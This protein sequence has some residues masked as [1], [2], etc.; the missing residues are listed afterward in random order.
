MIVNLSVLYDKRSDSQVRYTIIAVEIY[1]K[2]LLRNFCS[3][4]RPR[5]RSPRLLL[6]IPTIS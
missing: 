2:L 6:N 5:R 1:H 3:V 4:S